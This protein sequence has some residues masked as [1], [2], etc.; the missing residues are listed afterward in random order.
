MARFH[1]EDKELERILNPYDTPPP[2]DILPT[3]KNKSGRNT[4]L[5]AKLDENTKAV[6]Q[7]KCIRSPESPSSR[8]R[9]KLKSQGSKR[10]K[11]VQ[12]SLPI[13]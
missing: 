12:A 2:M 10:K 6:V 9:R 11:V 4:T 8:A 13:I 7:Q 1:I 3:I 5:R